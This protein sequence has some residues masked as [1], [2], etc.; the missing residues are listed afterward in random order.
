MRSSD[1]IDPRKM[2]LLKDFSFE[3]F[4]QLAQDDSLSRNEKVGFFE[5][6]RAG[7]ED[8]I[9]ADIRAKLPALDD[10]ER[11]VADIGC[12]CG[13]LALRLIDLCIAQGHTLILVDSREMLDQL[14]DGPLIRKVPGCYPAECEDL[15]REFKGKIDCILSYSVFQVVFSESNYIPFLDRSL[16]LL[17]EGGR[18]LIGD[19]PNAS[20]RKRFFQSA[21]GIRFHQ[22]NNQT[23]GLPEVAF[24]VLETGSIDD[25][26]VMGMALRARGFGFDGYVLPQVEGLPFA[27]RRE[28]LLIVRP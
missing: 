4:R 27:N 20:K 24:S 9:L 25:A 3:K 7:F 8:V 12:G 23:D 17:S 10:H 19:I 22:E 14:P 21:R 16:E 6:Y 15:L 18:L 11:V 1:S 26:V 5:Q 13:E 2:D 28:D